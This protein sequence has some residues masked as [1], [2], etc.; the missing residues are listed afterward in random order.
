VQTLGID[1]HPSSLKRAFRFAFSLNMQN[2]APIL[3]GDQVSQSRQRAKRN[4]LQMTELGLRR[5][6]VPKAGQKLYWDS[7][8]H[9]QRGLSVLMSS[10]G[11]KTYR[12]TFMLNDKAVSDKIGRVGEM[13]LSEARDLTRAL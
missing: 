4:K 7:G 2:C 1:L 3:G 11:A 9:G 6:R 5:Q 13:G 8:D 12:A 10:G